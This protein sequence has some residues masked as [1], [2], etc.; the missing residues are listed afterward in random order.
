MQTQDEHTRT[1]DPLSHPT[2]AEWMGFLYGKL[3]VP[4]RRELGG[5]LADCP[6]CSARV[7]AWRASQY[8]LDEWV[9]PNL[10]PA[11][12][13]WFPVLRW[14]AA[15]ALVLGMGTWLGRSMAPSG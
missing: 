4:R 14:A 2:S 11:Q 15:T 9:L 13:T 6:E 12:R 7:K 1:P 5:H 3:A 10:R 8:D